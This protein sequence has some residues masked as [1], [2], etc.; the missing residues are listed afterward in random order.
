MP[1]IVA[2]RCQRAASLVDMR[3]MPTHLAEWSRSPCG[4]LYIVG[5]QARVG[6][7]GHV[8]LCATCGESCQ[9]R[10]AAT[11]GKSTCSDNRA[12]RAMGSHY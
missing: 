10:P 11:L 6:G 8:W 4:E 12:S 1:V 7:D 2:H 9:R 3:C 5:N